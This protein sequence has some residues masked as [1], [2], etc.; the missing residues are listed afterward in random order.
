MKLFLM[1]IAIFFLFTN[2][3]SIA[4]EEDT[5]NE[6]QEAND[7]NGENNNENQNKNSYSDTI[8][9][10][11]E[12]LGT[13]SAENKAGAST[14]QIRGRDIIKPSIRRVT[15]PAGA[16]K[17]IPK[18]ETSKSASS[19]KIIQ[20]AY[21]AFLT[22]NIE[23]ALFY[24]Q[25]AIKKHPENRDAMFGVAVCYQMLGQ[26]DDAIREYTRILKDN[27]EDQQ[28]I[29]NLIVLI[30][31]M[32]PQRAINELGKMAIKNPNS[33]F[34]QAQIGTIQSS[35]KNYD[36]AIL[37]LGN[38]I[39]IEPSNPVYAYNLAVTLDKMKKYCEAYEYYK[40]SSAL[41]T[42]Q[43][44]LEKDVILDRMRQIRY[45]CRAGS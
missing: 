1:L 24:Y 44:P 15:I 13:R 20:D 40:H 10:M 16:V 25:E 35:M 4:I 21:D 9:M 43:T 3:N 22:G 12:M 26:N 7:A 31:G 38:A 23:A 5:S 19:E 32:D 37:H 11:S 33:S 29:N 42:P 14:P 2:E 6:I 45:E 18:S 28:S 27:P 8:K 34:I 39:A 41:I 30:S 17:A 36:K